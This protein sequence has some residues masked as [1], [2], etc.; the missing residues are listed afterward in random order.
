MY[1]IRCFS[2]KKV[3]GNLWETWFIITEGRC[4]KDAYYKDEEINLHEP[5]RKKKLT[6]KEKSYN[7]KVEKKNSKL[8]KNRKQKVVV[9]DKETAVKKVLDAYGLE[10]PISKPL[11][12]D[13]LDVKRQC[14]RTMM[15]SSVVYDE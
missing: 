15:F 2:C 6:A 3:L 9:V 7:E 14:C 8:P 4:I 13:L 10:K 11:A 12:A 5:I 1:P